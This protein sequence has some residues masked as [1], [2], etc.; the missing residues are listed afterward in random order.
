MKPKILVIAAIPRKGLTELEQKCDLIYPTQNFMFTDEEIKTH[1]REVD[2]VLSV[3]TRPF[4]AEM[5]NEGKQ[6]KIVANF[7]VGFNNIDVAKATEMDIVVCNTPN[8][9]TEPTAEM[10]FGLLLS[11]TRNIALTDRCL[12][13]NPDF[14]WGMMENLGTGIFGKTVG[15]VGMGRIGQ[16]F[17]RRAIASGMKVIYSNRTRLP[18]DIEQK[19]DSAWVGMKELLE[20]SDVISLHC[21][22]TNETHHL[23]DGAAMERMKQGAIIINTARGPVVDEKMLVKYLKN[24]K[25]GGAGLDVFEA[26][27]VI[28]PELFA[29]D[30]VVLTPHNATGTIDTRIEI[31]HEAAANILGF[32]E[33]RRDISIVNPVVWH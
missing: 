25:L 10:A 26:E 8:A 20:R 17:A 31:A 30:N 23:L 14:R 18:K 21:P 7:G 5:L 27:P 32:F 28:T 4:T 19:Y 15:I 3:F 13:S 11:L 29:L 24:G 16:A 33:G 12:R 22:L 6:V 1:I 2:G 9:V